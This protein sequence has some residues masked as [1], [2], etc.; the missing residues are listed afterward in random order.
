MLNISISVEDALYLQALLGQRPIKEAG[1]V[2][3]RFVTQCSEAQIKLSG[4]IETIQ[5]KLVAR[6]KK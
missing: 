2:H 4:E 5:A 6:R 3:A 1:A